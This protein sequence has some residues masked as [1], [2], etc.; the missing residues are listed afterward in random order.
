MV[1]GTGRRRGWMHHRGALMTAVAGVVRSHV[2]HGRSGG[3]WRVAVLIRHGRT[4]GRRWVAVFRASR[5]THVVIRSNF[6]AGWEI[7]GW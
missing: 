6:T 5:L 7:A 4:G 3:R 2:G 1:D